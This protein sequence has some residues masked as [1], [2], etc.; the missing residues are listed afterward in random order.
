MEAAAL[1]E[2]FENNLETIFGYIKKGLD[3]RTTPY[4]ISMPLE[5]NLLC[6]VLNQKGFHFQVTKGGFDAL[7]EFHD[8]YMREGKHVLDAMHQILEDKRA[9]IKTGDGTVLLKEQLIRRLE[10]F[11]EIAH[12]MEVIARLQQLGSPLQYNYPF[13]NK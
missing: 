10:Y 7:V 3:V 5:I 11:N 4:H 13:L 1:Y 6:D 12:S 2:R 8:L 9:Y